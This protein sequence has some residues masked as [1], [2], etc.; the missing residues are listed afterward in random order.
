M[1]TQPAS[2]ERT[3]EQAPTRVHPRGS[4][5][6][7]IAAATG[8]GAAHI[9]LTII[10]LIWITPSL[11]LLITSFRTPEAVAQSG[12]WTALLSG[13]FTL[14]NYSQVLFSEQF[15][16]T[17]DFINSIL[18]TF[19]ATVLTI[20]VS[21]GSAYAFAWLRFPGRNVLY[22]MTIVLLVVPL[23]TTWV[24]VLQLFNWLGVTGTW[25]AIWLAHTAYGA[26]F[27]IFLLRNFFAELPKDVFDM[28]RVD[29]A[30]EVRIF[31]RI[32]LPM[33]LPAIAS[34]GIFQFVWVW[35]DLMNALIFLQ[36]QS[37]YPLT[38]GIRDLLSQY[39]SEWHLLAAGT[40][41]AMF[42]PILIFLLLR[43]QFV[44]GVTAGSVKE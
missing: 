22:L 33:S 36:D 21:A 31:F 29:G 9:I 23:Q 38:V 5:I 28:A 11:G 43:Q 17:Q 20:L 40:W 18:I 15:N 30:S 19:P 34:L 32:L 8:Q 10:A 35:N 24:P 42:L 14:D 2:T 13:Q 3:D 4:L 37:R 39:G 1:S 26:S 44:R 27:A 25:I 16:F 6:S 41:V 12:W 7:Q